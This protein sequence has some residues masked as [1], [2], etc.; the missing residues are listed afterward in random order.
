VRVDFDDRK[1]EAANM[2]AAKNTDTDLNALRDDLAA[3]KNDM[4][5][6]VA[7]MTA[8]AAS[9]AQSA[10]SQIDQ[11]ARDAYR[12]ATAEGDRAAKLVGQKVEEQPITALLIALGI[13]YISGRILSR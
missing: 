5:S 9:G 12:T 1:T 3:L 11:K 8:S 2:S 13:G 4:A 7:N 6:L 10:A